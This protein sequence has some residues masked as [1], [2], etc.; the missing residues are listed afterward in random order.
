MSRCFVLISSHCFSKHSWG[1]SRIVSYFY[2]SCTY[3]TNFCSQRVL[4]S[5]DTGNLHISVCLQSS[6]AVRKGSRAVMEK[7]ACH[8]GLTHLISALLPMF[9][10]LIS[11]CCMAVAKIH[12]W[13][14]LSRKNLILAPCFRPVSPWQG[15]Y[16]SVEGEQLMVQKTGSGRRRRKG[17][18]GERV[19]TRHWP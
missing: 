4:S 12:V 14:N 10:H 3:F 19:S 1:T 15:V 7:D 11:S 8:L 18:E 6:R 9:D 5:P 2:K 16:G 13:K 17:E